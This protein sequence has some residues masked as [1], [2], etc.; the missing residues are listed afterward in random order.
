M[1]LFRT[2]TKVSQVRDDCTTLHPIIYPTTCASAASAW[3]SQKRM[4]MER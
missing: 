4:S 1:S 3:G 2:S